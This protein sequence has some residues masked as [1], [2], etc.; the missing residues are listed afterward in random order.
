[1]VMIIIK[2]TPIITLPARVSKVVNSI[3]LVLG[4]II[5]ILVFSTISTEFY[6]HQPE[7]EPTPI[8][9]LHRYGMQIKYAVLTSTLLFVV[10]ILLNRKE[11]WGP[12]M[13]FARL[14]LLVLFTH[15]LY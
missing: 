8:E 3:L 15:P 5:I 1:T 13:V 10:V 2:F 12:S 6:I 9:I 4:F 11:T 14:G 7:Y